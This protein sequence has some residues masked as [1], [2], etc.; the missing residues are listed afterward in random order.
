MFF[1]D[2]G[3]G[4]GLELEGRKWKGKCVL[5]NNIFLL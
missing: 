2:I 1:G 5:W 4:I 3:K